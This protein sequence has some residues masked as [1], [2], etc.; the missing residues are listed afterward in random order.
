MRR[1]GSKIVSVAQYRLADTVFFGFILLVGELLAIF[2]PKIVVVNMPLTVSLMLPITLLVMMR[3]G[4][5]AVFYST[6]S[7]VLRCAVAG[8][9]WEIYLIYIIGNA[10]LMLLLFATKYLGKKRI[11]GSWYFSVLFVVAGWLA[12]MLGRSAVGACLQMNFLSLFQSFCAGELMGLAIAVV[13]ILIMRRLDG[14][15]EDQ[16]E[17]LIRQDKERKLQQ[18][19]DAYG[20]EPVDID[21]ESLSVLKGKGDKLY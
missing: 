12:V 20:D 21:E 16:K 18:Q 9:G 2:A 10:F 15:F 7:A 1:F 5:I 8:S 6:L 3:W 14:M 19:R 4:W 17:Y 13:V 11:A